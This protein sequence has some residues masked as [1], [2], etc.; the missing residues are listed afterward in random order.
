MCCW[1]CTIFQVTFTMTLMFI[2]FMSGRLAYYPSAYCV[3][4][5][6][7]FA[8]SYT[9]D[10]IASTAFMSGRLAYYP[11]AYNVTIVYQVCW[12]IHCGCYCQYSFYVGTF[13]VL[14]IPL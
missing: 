8:G 5:F 1:A 7:R 4:L 14:S 13:G 10:V 6:I 12:F 2:L 11:C 3:T 9:V